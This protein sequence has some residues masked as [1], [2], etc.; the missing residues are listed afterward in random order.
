MAAFMASALT[1]FVATVVYLLLRRKSIDGKK[2]AF[3]PI[4]HA[5]RRTVCEPA[6]AWM[7]RR[8]YNQAVDDK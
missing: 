7:Q 8:G 1:A 5:V 6:Q 4:D 3:N 2:R